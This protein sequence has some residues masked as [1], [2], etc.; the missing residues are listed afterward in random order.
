EMP[1]GPLK[2][3]FELIDRDKDGHINKAEY[4]FM[5]RV[6]DAAHNRII[7]IKPGGVGDISNSHVLWSQRRNL[8]IVPSPLHYKGHL[9]LAR[10][11]GLLATLD[12][13][14]GQLV[15]HERLAGG[16][17]YY[18]SPVGGDGKVYLLSQNGNLTVV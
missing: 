8:P 12:A 2:Q 17:D 4:D 10:S 14:T 1:E 7:A 13:K 3:R 9:F 11:G 6:F 15:K 16:G 18:A 5:K